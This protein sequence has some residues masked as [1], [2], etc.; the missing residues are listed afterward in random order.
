MKIYS[1][2]IENAVDQISSLPGIGKRTALRLVIELLKRSNEEIEDFSNSFV[3]MKE[4]IK[5]CQI[6][7]NISDADICPIC[8]DKNRDQN[9]I[10]VVEDIRDILAI[11]AT[12]SY[13]GVYHVLDGIISPMDGIGPKDLNINSLIERAKNESVK[14]II[15]AL[16]ATMEGDTTNFYLYRKIKDLNIEISSLSRGVSV[17][18][19]LQYADE[20]TL[21]RSLLNRQ[22]FVI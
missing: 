8:S 10:C 21:S 9:L 5:Q 13:K 15:F 20:I 7:H 22:P 14:E 1:K 19:E 2:Y 18:A 6:C 12:Q 11:E 17:G 3:L 16:S 4:N